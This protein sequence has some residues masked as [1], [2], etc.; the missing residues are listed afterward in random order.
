MKL[1]YR[2]VSYDQNSRTEATTVTEGK[3]RGRK[4][5][6]HHQKQRTKPSGLVYRGVAVK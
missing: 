1:Q 2:G 4:W 3:F 5:T 6:S